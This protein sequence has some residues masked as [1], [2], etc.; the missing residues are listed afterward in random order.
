L[1]D[2]AYIKPNLTG[3]IVTKNSSSRAVYGAA[4]LILVWLSAADSG[5]GQTVKFT[6]PVT[7]SAGRPFV[8]STGDFN[9]DG[10]V[11]LVAG[12]I[13][14]N[15]VV[16]LLG[17]GDGTLQSP[18]TYHVSAHPRYLVASD[19][20]RDGKLDLAFAD[21]SPAHISILMGKGDGSFESTASYPV[22]GV[23]LL[24]G[25]FN[26]DG[27]PDLATRANSTS[28]AVLLNNGDGTFQNPQSLAVPH[29]LVRV[30]A[31][32][33]FNGDGKP[34]LF[35]YGRSLNVD[36]ARLVS[37]FLGRGDGT[38]QSPINTNGNWGQ[39]SGPYSISVGDFDRDGKLDAAV[40]DE[41]LT[42]LRGN[43]D[44]TFKTPATPLGLQ[45]TSSD[46]KVSDF[47]GDGKLDLVSAGVFRGGNL[48]VLL[49]AGDGT[50]QSAGS[51]VNDVGGVSVVPSDLNGDTR[52]DL[53]GCV[54]GD[55]SVALVNVTPGNPDNTDYFVHQQYADFLDREPDAAGFDFWANQIAS[56]G[57][58]PQCVEVKRINTSAAFYL[59]IEFQR[60]AYLVERLYKTAYGDFMGTSNDGG[61]HQ[62][63]VPIVRLNELLTDAEQI[64]QNVVVLRAGWENVLDTN[65]QSFVAQF[66][67]RPRFAAALPTATTPAAFVDKLNQNAGNVLS[68]A[69]RATLIGLFGSA[70][71]TGN[72]TVRAQVL[73]QIA[74]NRN[75]YDAEL[76]R[77]FV[78]MQYVGYLRRNPN[79]A[80]E[81]T[82]DYTGYDFWLKKLNQFN[83][84]F[85]EAEM[86]K[87]FITSIEYRQRFQP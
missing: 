52:P 76:N 69:E 33:D 62:L 14:N 54:N 51:L 7:Y 41:F 75:L 18:L 19:F 84:N 77:A 39:G 9:G 82:R 11:D 42:V 24:A 53:A 20:N 58:N 27:K 56:C 72:L 34:D 48:Q 2:T 49:G 64:N 78:L 23:L 57:A 6:S 5:I 63:A 32:G 37:L 43:G 73:R 47:N 61:T 59:S 13:T 26:N 15:D 10:K 67:Q 44:G 28:L 16:M 86:V 21:G 87:A 71:D 35:A 12:D 79:D 66:V 80:P 3:P 83:G 46:L 4:L 70:A 68:S 22:A 17:N 25:D 31:A 81:T 38:F 74:E 65:Q 1:K 29:P 85:V 36:S 45:N 40:T 60:T 55:L 8:V 50:F 30:F